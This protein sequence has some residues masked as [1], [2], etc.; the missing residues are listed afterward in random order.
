MQGHLSGNN[1]DQSRNVI[2][3]MT[4]LKY[5]CVSLLEG[6]HTAYKCVVRNASMCSTVED[7]EIIIG[8]DMCVSNVP[9]LCH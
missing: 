2:R 1:R 4:V 5:H 9:M 6:R 8:V 3:G 7:K